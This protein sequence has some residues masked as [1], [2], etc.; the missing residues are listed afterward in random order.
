MEMRSLLTKWGFDIEHEKLDKTEK[1]L[2]AIK[3][4]LDFLAGEVHDA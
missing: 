3:D 4:R 1:Q 2:E